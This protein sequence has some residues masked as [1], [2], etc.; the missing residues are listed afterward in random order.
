VINPL[1][2]GRTRSNKN[3]GACLALHLT[4]NPFLDCVITAFGYCF[5]IIVGNGLVPFNG[6]DVSYLTCPGIVRLELKAVEAVP[7]H[8]NYSLVR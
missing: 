3:N 7:S 6:P 1:S 5:P 2:V 4:H 8:M